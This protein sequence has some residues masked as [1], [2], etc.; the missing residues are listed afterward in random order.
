M[1]ELERR[2]E[3]YGTE[4]NGEWI[5]VQVDAT[6]ERYVMEVFTQSGFVSATI[7]AFAKEAVSKIK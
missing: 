3:I 1:L 5:E 7:L 6:V 2:I 4:F